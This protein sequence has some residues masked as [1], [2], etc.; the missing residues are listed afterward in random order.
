MRCGRKK[1]C[2]NF[3]TPLV[4]INFAAYAKLKKIQSHSKPQAVLFEN[5]VRNILKIILPFILGFGILWWMYRDMNLEEFADY[6][7]HRMNWGWMAVSLVFGLLAQ[8]MRAWRWKMVL[9]PL[10][11]NPRRRICEDA[12]FLSYASSL[13][14]P[15]IGEVTRCGTL[16]KYEGIPFSKA[17]GTV[18]TERMVDS[19][20][21]M[22]LTASIFLVQLT[23][24]LHFLKKT[25]TDFGSSFAKYTG[26]GYIVTGFCA[27]AIIALVAFLL[28]KFKA[29]SKGKDVLNNL[30]TGVTSLRHIKRF[31]L[32]ASYSVGIWLCYFLHFYIAFFCFDFTS[33]INPLQAFLI[34]C[35]GTFA[36]L[37]PT[38][39]GA[40]PWHFV[41]KTLLVLYGVGE[42]QAL[43]FAFVIHTIQT[44]EVVLLGAFG[45]I[46]LSMRKSRNG[47]KVD[48]QS[49]EVGQGDITKENKEPNKIIQQ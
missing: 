35:M 1:S 7:F 17:L 25:G 9:E 39:N 46:D 43:M 26:T 48:S 44:F 30:W 14:V 16:K 23:D 3:F 42:H 13:I 40:G 15:R 10:G 12:I 6:V 41:V 45:W 33:S 22:V 19:F 36:V 18:V 27:I 29:F 32:Y 28:T 38:P 2:L 4:C 31:P 49:L 11:E 47:G 37:V 34:F 8:Q 20:V 24:F 21:I 5:M